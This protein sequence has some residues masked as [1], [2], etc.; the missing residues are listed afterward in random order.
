MTIHSLYLCTSCPTCSPRLPLRSPVFFK[1]SLFWLPLLC[2]SL[3]ISYL[4]PRR[5]PDPALSSPPDHP[6]PK[7]QGDSLDVRHVASEH[8]PSQ[9]LFLVLPLLGPS[10]IVEDFCQCA[11]L[12]F[13][14][15]MR[16][17]EVSFPLLSSEAIS[18]F[19]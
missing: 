1:S 2:I 18:F 19:S 3:G 16:F 4:P 11:S 7:A 9:R 8:F 6:S 12:E 10:A 5:R 14:H 17:L 15:F 13:I